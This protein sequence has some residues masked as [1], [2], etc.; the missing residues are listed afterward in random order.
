VLLSVKSRPGHGTE[1]TLR[2][3]KTP[4]KEPL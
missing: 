4:P 3:T 1:L 2:W